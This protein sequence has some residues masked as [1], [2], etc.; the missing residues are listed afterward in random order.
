MCI[1]VFL[2]VLFLMQLETLPTL[3]EKVRDE[4]ET[5]AVRIFVRHTPSDPAQLPEPYMRCLSLGKPF[6][7]CTITGRYV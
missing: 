5:L 3:P 6:K 1:H 4:I 2:I 7:A